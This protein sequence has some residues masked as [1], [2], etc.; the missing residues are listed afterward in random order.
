M[1]YYVYLKSGSVCEFDADSCSVVF[2]CIIYTLK[3]KVVATIVRDEIAA[4]IEERNKSLVG[5]SY[6]N[7]KRGI[8]K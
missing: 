4:T 1:R 8:L 2:P 6:Y 7:S 5:F 3:G